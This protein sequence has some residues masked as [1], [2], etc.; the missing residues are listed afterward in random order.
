MQAQKRKSGLYNK[1]V[2]RTPWNA[3]HQSP[4]N[5]PVHTTAFLD[6]LKAMSIGLPIKKSN[7][8]LLRY[9]ALAQELKCATKKK[10]A[11]TILSSKHSPE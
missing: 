3:L 1:N 2:L 5:I 8:T 7:R 4:P 11:Q 10:L 9:K 6:G